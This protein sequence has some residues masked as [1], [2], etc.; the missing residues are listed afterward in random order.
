[1]T[2]IENEIY[3]SDDCVSDAAINFSNELLSG[4][5]HLLENLRFHKEEKENCEIFA[6]RLSEHA[7]VF[8]N[9]AFGV[10]HRNHASNSSILNYFDKNMIGY[11]FLIEKELKYFGNVINNPPK[12]FSLVLG[13]AKIED[14][15]KMIINML[16]NAI[17]V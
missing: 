9:D 14:K 3:F 7:D 8:I 10:C 4:E 1:M 17:L 5:I 16:S 6:E 12:P 15:I 2:N 13:G 11:G